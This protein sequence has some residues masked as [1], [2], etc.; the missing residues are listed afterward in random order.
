MWPKRRLIYIQSYE[1]N[2]DDFVDWELKTSSHGKCVACMLQ[3]GYMWCTMLQIQITSYTMHLLG[4]HFRNYRDFHTLT[5]RESFVSTRNICW[6]ISAVQIIFVAHAK[7][8]P[9]NPSSKKGILPSCWK[10]FGV[11]VRMQPAP[12]N[13]AGP[14]QERWVFRKHGISHSKET[15]RPI[16][17]WFYG[18]RHAKCILEPKIKRESEARRVT[19]ASEAEKAPTSASIWR[20]WNKA[21][22]RAPE[23]QR[24]WLLELKQLFVTWA[25]G[26]HRWCLL[27]QTQVQ[28]CFPDMWNC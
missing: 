11:P 22:R 10:W 21:D 25:P 28:V 6:I 3:N 14:S 12:G 9:L 19:D 13:K 16:L 1:K 18:S 7:R 17:W 26:F 24:L 8:V 15:F 23:H 20:P 2:F 4:C 5:R 27:P